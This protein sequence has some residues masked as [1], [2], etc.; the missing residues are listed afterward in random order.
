MSN[1]DSMARSKEGVQH[2]AEKSL[3]Y[4]D[5][6]G[7][8]RNFFGPI[9]SNGN[10]VGVFDA[11]QPRIILHRRANAIVISVIHRGNLATRA[12]VMAH[13]KRMTVSWRKTNASIA[14][15]ATMRMEGQKKK[16]SRV[17]G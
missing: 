7:G 15:Y 3:Q 9:V 14:R 5:L 1:R 6:G 13:T 12:M 2:I 16:Q 11:S 10:F 17:N 8:D 4:I